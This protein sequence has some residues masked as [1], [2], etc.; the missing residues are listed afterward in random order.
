MNKFLL[1]NKLHYEVVWDLDVLGC[2]TKRLSKCFSKAQ[3]K[4]VAKTGE[5]PR[6][7]LG[8]PGEYEFDCSFCGQKLG[9]AGELR[10][11]YNQVHY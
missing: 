1:D 9:P 2:K 3:R 6:H 8:R 11:H 7:S 4:K 5:K 10:Q